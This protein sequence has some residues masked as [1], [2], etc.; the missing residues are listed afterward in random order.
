MA[1]AT[2]V[3]P[4]PGGPSK[5]MPRRAEPPMVSRKVWWAKK[6]LMERT[7]SVLIP[8]IPTR[9]SSPTSVSPG[10]IKVCGERPAPRNGMAMTAPSIRTISRMGSIV[11]SQCGRWTEGSTLCPVMER[12]TTQPSTR[13]SS[14][15]NR[16]SRAMRWCSRARETSALPKMASPTMPVM[17]AVALPEAGRGRDAGGT[18][19]AGRLMTRLRSSPTDL[20]NVETRTCSITLRSDLSHT[21]GR[22]DRPLGWGSGPAQPAPALVAGHPVGPGPDRPGVPPRT[23]SSWRFWRPGA[24]RG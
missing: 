10:R 8:S 9:S 21:Y 7:T 15:T 23:A 5:R 4:V 12:M 19:S 13:L 22:I 11:P 3:L 18:C 20:D 1:L 16:R 14:A 6:R 2:N 24:A 17:A